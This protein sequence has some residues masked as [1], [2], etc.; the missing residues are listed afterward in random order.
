[1]KRIPFVPALIQKLAPEMGI[2]VLLE[3]Q[4]Q[5]LGE[6]VLPNGKH[7][8]FLGTDIGINNSASAAIAQ[9][10]AYTHF[11]L[12]RCE[13]NVPDSKVF[14]ADRINAKLHEDNGIN[15]AIEW[16]RKI[17]FPIYAKPNNLGHGELVARVTSEN[18]FKVV[19]MHIFE[20]TDT[21]IVE[22]EFGGRDFRVIVYDNQV[23]AAYERIAFGIEGDGRTTVDALLRAKLERAKELGR[24]Q[25]DFE[26]EDFTIDKALGRQ[27]VARHTIPDKGVHIR[28]LDNA[29]LSTGGDA[30]DFSETLHP[31]FAQLAVKSAAAVGLKLCGVDILADDI[32]KS[33]SEQKYCVLELNS[34]P[35]LGIFH[36]L[37]D[38][39]KE[40][41]ENIYR[42]M[43]KNIIEECED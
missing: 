42:L 20:R 14:S 12:K 24:I 2:G 43:L 19:A 17:G 25:K 35:A 13:I 18:E 9:D 22:R 11:L 7:W 16:V 4:W 8:P 38:K 23:R 33:P 30:I 34:K 37:G 31:E 6:L 1:M 27:K 26:P 15:K 32:S 29:S 3:P 36:D 41:V 28:L 5:R 10:K 21:M 40:R 39:Q